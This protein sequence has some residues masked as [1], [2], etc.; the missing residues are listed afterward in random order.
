MAISLLIETYLFCVCQHTSFHFLTVKYTDV[1]DTEKASDNGK[2]MRNIKTH[3]T[4]KIN[5]VILGST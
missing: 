3:F 1:Y 4:H 5:L 2:Y